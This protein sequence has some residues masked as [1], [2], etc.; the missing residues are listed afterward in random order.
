MSS[1]ARCPF[2]TMHGARTHAGAQSNRDWWPGRLEVGILRQHGAK[3][4]P[5]GEAFNYAEEFKSLD[6]DADV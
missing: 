3:S 5:M 1:E 4:N 2:A 6:L